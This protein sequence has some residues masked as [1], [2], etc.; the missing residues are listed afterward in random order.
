MS[1]CRC[2]TIF[3][4]NRGMLPH[5]S[6]VPARGGPDLAGERFPE[7]RLPRGAS[8]IGCLLNRGNT[9]LAGDPWALPQCS[10]RATSGT[11]Y[12]NSLP[13]LPRPIIPISRR[14][15]NLMTASIRAPNFR[16]T[17]HLSLW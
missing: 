10:G 15:L 13:I 16:I 12:R 17:H 9:L 8:A 7:R 2:T 11:Q 14:I 5:S 6:A 4:L 1:V 3:H